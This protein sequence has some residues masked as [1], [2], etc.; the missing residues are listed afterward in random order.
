VIELAGVEVEDVHV[1]VEARVHL[2]HR[3]RAVVRA[4]A[5]D[6]EP[7]VALVDA[8]GVVADLVAA[9]HV[10]VEHRL[11]PAV[12]RERELRAVGV[13]PAPV[14]DRIGGVGQRGHRLPVAVQ[15]EQLGALVAALVHPE[16]QLVALGRPRREA[17]PLV[18]EGE[19]SGPP[20]RLVESP[21]LRDARRVQ[22]H[23]E[24]LAVRAERGSGRAPHVE[25][26]L[27]VVGRHDP[28]YRGDGQSV[29]DSGTRRWRAR[30]RPA[31]RLILYWPRARNS[32]WNSGNRRF[33]A[34]PLPGANSVETG[35][36]PRVPTDGSRGGG[37]ER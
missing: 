37:G 20:R 13:P 14:V 36:D 1:V 34:G 33:R 24:P 19:L 17:D 30:F 11:V 12:R 6:G 28:S 5:R 18:L 22:Q 7:A 16:D 31:S 25:I 26:P 29:L 4:P 10:D 3:E 21:H 27:E 35:R 8:L 23:R 32:E 2:D 15:P 9:L